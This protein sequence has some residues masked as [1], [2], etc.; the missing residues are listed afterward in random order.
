MI[1]SS[2]RG[3]SRDKLSEAL[4]KNP[5]IAF[6]LLNVAI[7]L[8]FYDNS[9]R[10]MIPSHISLLE[11]GALEGTSHKGRA[12]QYQ[13]YLDT[14]IQFNRLVMWV[15]MPDHLSRPTIKNKIDSRLDKMLATSEEFDSQE[16]SQLISDC[17]GSIATFWW[18]IELQSDG[19]CGL[20]DVTC[21]VWPRPK[22]NLFRPRISPMKCQYIRESLN[23]FREGK[24][25]FDYGQRVDQG[26]S[27]S[28]LDLMDGV[29]LR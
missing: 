23:K 27:T 21:P 15:F 11:L 10:E 16:R 28:M 2:V 19:R 3:T 29:Q 20:T 1:P 4:S 13:F 7:L 18:C 9:A 12:I 5:N 26:K 17:W 24:Q 25:Y 6:N 22:D 8:L 14:F